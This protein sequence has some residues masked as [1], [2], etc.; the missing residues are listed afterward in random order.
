MKKSVLAIC[1]GYTT[2][3]LLTDTI[4]KGILCKFNM[5]FS[6]ARSISKAL[7]Q[8][9]ICSRME[10]ITF[11]NSKVKTNYLIKIIWYKI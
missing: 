11:M 3:K 1:N 5:R 2:D 8:M 4:A 6:G 9:D 7:N 10:N